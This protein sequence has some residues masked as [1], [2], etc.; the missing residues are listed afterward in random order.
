MIQ[1][2]QQWPLPKT[3]KKLRGGGLGLEGYYRRFIRGYGQISKPLTHLLKKDCF[4]WTEPVSTAFQAL[5]NALTSAPVLALPDFNL[6]F[7]VE[8]D[9]CDMG[10][11][12]V[13]MQKGQPIAYLSK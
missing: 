11:G 13:I 7:A 12:V 5:K 3:I 8:T 9:A 1:V 2:L 6:P 10:I 4:K